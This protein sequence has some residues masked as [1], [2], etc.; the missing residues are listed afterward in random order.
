MFKVYVLKSQSLE[1]YYIGQTKHLDK[2]IEW[3]NS[4]RARWTRRYQP[5]VLVFSETYDSRSEAMVREKELK[6]LKNIKQFLNI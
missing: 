1:K 3:H 2:R 4:P 6:A 5:W